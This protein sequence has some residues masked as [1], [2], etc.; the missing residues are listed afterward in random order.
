MIRFR[1]AT[2]TQA[3]YPADAFDAVVMS[4]VL[5]HLPN[6]I[7]TLQECRRVLKPGGRLISITPNSDSLGRKLFREW[8]GAARSPPSSVHLQQ[9]L[10][11]APRPVN[12]IYAFGRVLHGKR[13]REL[14]KLFSTSIKLARDAK[15]EPPVSEQN[16]RRYIQI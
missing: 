16:M 8:I 2:S 5:E 9:R 13:V 14:H 1:S 3:K 7:E 4:N 12:R 15:R 10:L 6:P 11:E